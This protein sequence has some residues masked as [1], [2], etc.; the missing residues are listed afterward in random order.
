MAQSFL[1]ATAEA[2]AFT[3][4]PSTHFLITL[5]ITPRPRRPTVRCLTLTWK[6]K[7]IDDG[8]YLIPPSLTVPT[9]S[10]C[11][12]LLQVHAKIGTPY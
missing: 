7:G 5:Y 12:P 6:Q 4:T 9:L 2:V 8:A 10:H 11:S 3:A 1:R